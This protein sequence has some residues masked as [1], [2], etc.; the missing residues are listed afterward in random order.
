[1]SMYQ[2]RTP[3]VDEK[4]QESTDRETE[5]ELVVGKGESQDQQRYENQRKN[6]RYVGRVLDS[7]ERKKPTQEESKHLHHH[8]LHPLRR[9]VR[10]EFWGATAIGPWTLQ[11]VACENPLHHRNSKGLL[12]RTETDLE[13]S[14]SL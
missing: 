6:G 5:P 1:M 13:R 7:E 14:L 11:P 12:R 4:E 8:L 3:N 2:D 9:Q 10:T